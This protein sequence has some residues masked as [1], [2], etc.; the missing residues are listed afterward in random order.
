VRA[1]QGQIDSPVVK[2]SYSLVGPETKKA[3]RRRFLKSG[4]WPKV[5][6]LKRR[7]AALHRQVDVQRV[8]DSKPCPPG[9]TPSIR[10]R[11][12]WRYVTC[13]SC[14]SRTRSCSFVSRPAD[15]RRRST[16]SRMPTRRSAARMLTSR[17]WPGGPEH[18]PRSWPSPLCRTAQPDSSK[19]IRTR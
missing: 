4:E 10:Q 19:R 9:A 8:A 13:A 6:E 12:G 1:R 7:F 17:S 14:R 15:V 3:F 11:S 18:A 2:R 16:E 5:S